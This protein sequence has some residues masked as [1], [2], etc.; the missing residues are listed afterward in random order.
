MPYKRFAP[1]VGLHPGISVVQM[2][3]PNLGTPEIDIAVSESKMKV[4]LLFPFQQDS[5]YVCMI[6]SFHG[7]SHM[8][9]LNILRN[10]AQTML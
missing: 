1:Y 10:G 2:R 4:S 9:M 5:T 7:E 8:Y 3:N 6:H